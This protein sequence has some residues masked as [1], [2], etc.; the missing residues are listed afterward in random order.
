FSTAASI[1]ATIGLGFLYP[2]K[3][4]FVNTLIPLFAVIVLLANGIGWFAHRSPVRGFIGIAGPV[5][6]LL[7]VYTLSPHTTDRTA[8][9]YTGLALMTAF[10]LWDS[11]IRPRMKKA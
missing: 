5:L 2:W 7:A 8:V 4:L 10:G 6:V 1:G 3:G 11:F 9:L